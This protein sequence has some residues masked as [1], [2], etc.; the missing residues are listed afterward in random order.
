MHWIIE[1]IGRN[2]SCPSATSSIPYFFELKLATWI[3]LIPWIFHNSP[4]WSYVHLNGKAEGHSGNPSRMPTSLQH[5]P[6]G[7]PTEVKE[8][9]VSASQSLLHVFPTKFLCNSD[10]LS[11]TLMLA[12][13]FSPGNCSTSVNEP[14]LPLF[15]FL[16]PLNHASW[17][18]EE[19]GSYSSRQGCQ[20]MNGRY[21]LH[22]FPLAPCSANLWNIRCEIHLQKNTQAA[23]H[24][25]PPPHPSAS[26]KL[27]P[28][29]SPVL[30]TVFRSTSSDCP[31][32]SHHKSSPE[33][34]PG[35]MSNPQEIQQHPM[36]GE[37]LHCSAYKLQWGSLFSQFLNLVTEANA[38]VRLSY[39]EEIEHS[40]MNSS[41][42]RQYF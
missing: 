16:P 10:N 26:L 14:S 28:E 5:R 13:A 37:L 24:F 31:L 39:L 23:A 18:R 19:C 3:F 36:P 30:A 8:N 40:S 25:L 21:W 22:V 42:T 32:P 9:E 12:T 11:L 4:C 38:R 17:R 41:R 33:Q 20:R 29:L 35:V 7:I 2:L 6:A 1:R 34:E 27:R 15:H